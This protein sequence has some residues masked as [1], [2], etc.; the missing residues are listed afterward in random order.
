L[1]RGRKGRKGNEK[2][3]NVP[4]GTQALG[5]VEWLAGIIHKPPHPGPTSALLIVDDVTRKADLFDT[6]LAVPHLSRVSVPFRWARLAAGRPSHKRARLVFLREP[7]REKKHDIDILKKQIM[8]LLF[9]VE[10]G[11]FYELFM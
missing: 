7:E 3:E 9:G 2:A 1:P 6:G 11:R 5:S 4:R 10:T 8:L